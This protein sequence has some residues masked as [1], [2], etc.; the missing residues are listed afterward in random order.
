MSSSVVRP[1]RI[2]FIGA[3]QMAG[4]HLD[5]LRRVATPHVVAGVCDLRPDAARA[6]ARRARATPYTAVAEFLNDARPDIVHICT[7]PATHFDLA[8]QALL[9][10]VHVYIEKPFAE[11]RA[12]A[13]TLFTLARERRLL[14]CAG[15]QLLR[16]P[17]FCSLLERATALQPLVLVDSYFSFRPPRL[18]PYRSAPA[19]LAEQLLDVLPH[20]LYT[21]VAALAHLVPH[22][23][24][25]ETAPQLVHVTA[26]PTDLHA[27]LRAGEATGRLAVSLRARPVASTLT[28]TGAHG[29]LT[30]D[31]VHGTVLGAGNDGTSPLEKIANPFVEAGQLAWGSAGGLARRL[32]R[33]ISYPGLAELLDEFYAAV[34]AGDRSPLSVEH[35]RRVTDIYEELAVQIRGASRPAMSDRTA[36]R[37][38]AASPV[39]PVAVVT[40]AAGFLGRALTRELARRGFR[41]RG[42]YRSQPSDD[43]HVHEWVRVD[44]GTAI[45]SDV[46]AGASVVLHAAA[47]TSGGFEAHQRD[48]V[49]ATRQVLRGMTAAGVHRLVYV[50]SISVLQPPRSARERQTEET[51]LAANAERLGPYTWGKCAAE[52]VVAAAHARREIVARIVRPAALFDWEDIDVPGLVGKR[53]FGR[54]HL[55]FGRPGLPF[56][57]CEVGMAAAALAWIAEH[58]ADAP[59]IINLMD[60]AINTRAGLLRQ[61][62]ERGWR[63]RFVWVP[64]PLLAGGVLAMSRAMALARRSTGGPTLSVWSVLRPRRYD[65]SVAGRVLAAAQEDRSLRSTDPPDRVVVGVEAEVSQAYG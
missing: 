10:G 15:H 7:H 49:D 59:P 8:R 6:L 36:S 39:A 63:G 47:A 18:N 27:V 53:L 48:S 30:T 13:E 37:L 4:Q 17:A 64:I 58:F 9:A 65:P 3:G 43:P 32:T 45:P 38:P 16:D 23:G 41:V 35:L 22:N 29:S 5:A 19:A 1:L 51:P 40:G 26:T 25:T 61:F 62:R 44:L 31:F 42:T 54:W 14:L 46:F 21:L 57:A 60:P 33:G 34:A 2:G 20:P 24:A 52:E 50:S 28:V 11:T 56:A 12:D 55:G